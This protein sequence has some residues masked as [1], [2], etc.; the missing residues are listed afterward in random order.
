MGGGSWSSRSY[1]TYAASSG[2][3]KA[4][5]VRDVYGKKGVQ[6]HL[7]SNTIKLRESRDSVEHPTSFPV[8][9]GLDVTGSMG[10][11]A[12]TIAKDQLADTMRRL[13]ESESSP[14]KDP[15]ILFCAIGDTFCDDHPFQAT[16]FESDIRIVEQ[17]RDIYFEGGGGGNQGES[18]L[19]AW[20][21][22]AFMTETDSFD[23][24]GVKG[25]LYTIGDEPNLQELPAEHIKNVFSRDDRDW[26]AKEL[27]EEAQKKWNVFHLVVKPV[28]SAAADW[29]KELGE[30]CLLIKSETDIPKVIE[31]H[32]RSTIGAETKPVT[33]EFVSDSTG[34]ID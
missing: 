24:R 12:V 14:V 20:Y 27:L 26:T 31:D 18:Y 9:F 5:D 7:A 32:V 34:V 23:K 10:A 21:F 13:V 16:Q 17:L 6:K 1:T 25:L 2:L 15:Q 28:R 22:A 29:K 19:L 4:R 33:G 8:V 3:S 11:T 30:G